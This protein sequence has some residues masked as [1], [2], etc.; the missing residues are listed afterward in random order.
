MAPYRLVIWGEKLDEPGARF[1]IGQ[2]VRVD[3][4]GAC[5]VCCAINEYNYAIDQL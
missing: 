1:A 2:Y 3:E 4:D 5:L